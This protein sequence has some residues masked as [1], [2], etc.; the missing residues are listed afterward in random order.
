MRKK[1][2]DAKIEVYADLVGKLTDKEI[3]RL[4]GMS[5]SCV[6]DYR[7]AR[8]TPACGHEDRCGN[9]DRAKMITRRDTLCES[10][11]E[12]G[13]RCKNKSVDE[14]KGKMICESC[15]NADFK[16]MSVTD[17]ISSGR[18]NSCHE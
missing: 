10:V 3:G 18:S 8:G 5:R 7:R 13:K 16:P 6:S 9:K 2:S 4:T 15:M 1:K 14:F 12:A 17:F 11:D